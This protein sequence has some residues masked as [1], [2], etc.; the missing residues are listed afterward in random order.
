MRFENLSD[1]F[2]GGS[3]SLA[4]IEQQGSWL[5]LERVVVFVGVAFVAVGS[6]TTFLIC[7]SDDGGT[8]V[9]VRFDFDSG[10][11]HTGSGR[12]VPITTG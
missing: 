12:V 9:V 1:P 2:R 11:T 3:G 8:N 5:G 4:F 10:R 7:P 6:T